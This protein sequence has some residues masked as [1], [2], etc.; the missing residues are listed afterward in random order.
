LKK[1]TDTELIRMDTGNR[2]ELVDILVKRFAGLV[3]AGL[4][5]G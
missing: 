2:E 1:R 3:S 4:N 5:A